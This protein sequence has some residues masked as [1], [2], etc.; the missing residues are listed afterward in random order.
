MNLSHTFTFTA[1]H[2]RQVL[3]LL[4]NTAGRLPDPCLGG[5]ILDMMIR[6]GF[7]IYCL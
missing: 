4:L 5:V 3:L 2:W 6:S 7:G 1:R